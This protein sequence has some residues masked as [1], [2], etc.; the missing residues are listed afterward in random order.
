MPGIL[1]CNAKVRIKD[2]DALCP[3]REHC[4]RFVALSVPTEQQWITPPG[5][6][7]KTTKNG[8]GG[9]HCNAFD[10]V[11]VRERITEWS[12]KSEKGRRDETD[13]R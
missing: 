9:W 8:N 1:K 11:T 7:A 10:L 6:F 3:I 2:S 12:H 5:H 13:R 4:Y